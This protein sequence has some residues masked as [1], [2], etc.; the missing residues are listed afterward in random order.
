MRKIP[1]KW[2][3]LSQEEKN[4]IPTKYFNINKNLLKKIRNISDTKKRLIE[5]AKLQY[6]LFEDIHSYLT[7]WIAGYGSDSIIREKFGST[8]NLLNLFIPSNKF[9]KDINPSWAD[10]KRK[11]KI[12]IKMTEEIAEETGIHIG[13]G[14]MH[15]RTEKNGCKSYQYSISG[16]LINEHIY[17]EDYIKPLLKSIY[18]IEASILKRENK[19]SI[20]TRCKSKSI[21]LF[22]NKILGLIIGKKTNIEI[23][24]QILKDDEFQKRCVVGIIDTDFNITSSLS[25]T[26]KLNNL[27]VLKEMKKILDKNK[28]PNILRLYKNYGRFYIGKEGALR[29][30]E[31]WKL[32]NQKHLSKFHLFGEFKKFVPY[33]TTPERL[34]VLAG[35]LDIK[36][37]EE[38]CKKRGSR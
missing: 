13:D 8:K 6:E 1:T 16:D 21:V 25:I 5:A 10:I 17:H 28:I 29:I 22:K 15:V 11:I 7:T 24:K 23:P 19:N 3:E 31:E 37:L 18:N 38:I 30:M 20:E 9:P 4:K 2:R 36:K 12:P 26:G 32:K 14:N 35:K 27:L 34:A 33:S